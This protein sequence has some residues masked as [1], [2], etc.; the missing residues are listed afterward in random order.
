MKDKLKQSFKSLK[1]YPVVLLFFVF[2]FGFMVLDMLWPKREKSELENRPLQQVPAFSW[3][4]L[5]NNEWTADYGDYV[6]DQ[7]AFRDAWIDLKARS[8]Y[9]LG[10]TENGDVIFAPDEDGTM[11]FTKFYSL[12][13]NES[14]Y[15]ANAQAV[16]SFAQR[17]EGKVTFLLAPSASVIYKDKLPAG[18]PLADE[19]SYLD[20]IFEVTAPYARNLDLRQLFR[21]HADEYIYYRTDHHW[22]TQGAYLAYEE[23]CRQLGLTPFDTAAHTAVEVEEFYGTS[24]SKSRL[25]NAVPD[26]LTYYPLDNAMTVEVAGETK[27]ETEGM[28]NLSA[29]DTRDKYSAFLWGNNGYSV[30][31]GD[32]EG[33]VLVVKDSYGN[34]FTPFL[35]ANYAQI[36]V[37]DLRYWP[38]NI[39][40]LAEEYDQILILYNFQSFYKDVGIRKLNINLNQ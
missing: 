35:T 3:R 5:F 18:V 20:N 31:E 1:P 2:L 15:L 40:Q 4:A 27:G 36:G 6:K 25:W 23:F 16:A 24:Y 28:Y 30:I 32:G 13:N 26:T 22:T 14:S 17:H 9:F 8:E 11:M 39:E 19:E 21:E 37:V 12:G 7:F 33:S 38:G 10:K 34:C 29:L